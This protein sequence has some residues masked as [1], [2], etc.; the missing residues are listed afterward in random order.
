MNDENSIVFFH[1]N[2]LF[3][4]SLSLFGDA[5]VFFS[6]FLRYLYLVDWIS[7]VGIL[8]SINNMH[9]QHTLTCLKK[10]LGLRLSVCG[11]THIYFY[12]YD[13]DYDDDFDDDDNIYLE[14][15]T[16]GVTFCTINL[17]FKIIAHFSLKWLP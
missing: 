16:H 2:V 3:L 14:N 5:D 6:V 17:S 12:I 1:Y 9:T 8:I 11:F 7:H 13:F 10:R 4:I 15:G